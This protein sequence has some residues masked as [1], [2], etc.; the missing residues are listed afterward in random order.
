MFKMTRN[1]QLALDA[2]YEIRES[3][4]GALSY[5]IKNLGLSEE[6]TAVL[7]NFKIDFNR[8]SEVGLDTIRI[9]AGELENAPLDFL[10]GEK[11]GLYVYSRCLSQAFDAFE[12]QA[13]F[14]KCPEDYFK[15]YLRPYLSLCI[16]AGFFSTYSALVC[17]NP[18]GE[19]E[20]GVYLPSP[21]T[22]WEYVNL[23]SEEYRNLEGTLKIT[24]PL[25]R[26]VGNPLATMVYARHQ[27]R[28]LPLLG[29]YLE[30]PSEESGWELMKRAVRLSGMDFHTFTDELTDRLKA[31]IDSLCGDLKIENN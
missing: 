12:I 31:K 17:W 1:K 30:N 27:E 24:V 18:H 6:Q 28:A 3:V 21:E 4:N 10:A 16:G 29:K 2:E 9:S 14:F 8:G 7:R 19:I 5:L 23:D 20:Y 13:H 11:T 25:T 15:N 22:F 26:E